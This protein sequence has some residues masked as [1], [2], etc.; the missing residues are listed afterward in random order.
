[1][2]PVDTATVTDITNDSGSSSPVTKKVRFDGILEEAVLSNTIDNLF[3]ESRKEKNNLTEAIEPVETVNSSNSNKLFNTTDMLTDKYIYPA[4][5]FSGEII[6]LLSVLFS[7]IS[8]VF[9]VLI[10]L[11]TILICITYYLQMKHIPI[12]N[13]IQ[14]L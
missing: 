8:T 1:M 4:V 14:A 10:T 11:V 5:I 2:D 7:N 9:K 13:I 6:I 3:E 12:S